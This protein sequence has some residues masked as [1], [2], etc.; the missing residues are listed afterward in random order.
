MD[1]N[2]SRICGLMAE[3]FPPQCGEPSV[4]LLDLKSESIVALMSPEDPTLAS[5]AWT[6][7]STSVEGV[8]GPNGLSG[9]KVLDPVHVS[10]SEDLVLR[11]ADLG[12]RVNEPVTWPFDL[13]NSTDTDTTLTFSNG[14]RLELMLSDKSGEVYRWSDGMFFTQAI[15][16]VDLGAGETTPYLLRADAL[17]VPPGEYTATAWVTAPE[18]ADVV[19]TWTVVITS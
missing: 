7:Y 4:K 2:G 18:A 16:Q 19:L 15:A 1:S 6:D 11:V 17:D 13:T 12:I 5:V 9:V 3:S 10:G 8:L 14:Q